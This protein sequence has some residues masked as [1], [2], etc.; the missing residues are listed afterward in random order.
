MEFIARAACK[1]HDGTASLQRT[2]KKSVLLL[3]M[4][5]Y[6]YV[7]EQPGDTSPL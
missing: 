2:N 4:R 3:F 5:D 7:T 1:R 6:R